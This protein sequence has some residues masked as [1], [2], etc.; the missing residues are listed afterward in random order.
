MTTTS[1]SPLPAGA[2]ETRVVRTGEP[3]ESLIRRI[4]GFVGW[5]LSGFGFFSVRRQH[6]KSE[7]IVL[8]AV[9]QSFYVWAL[10]LTGFI[11]A[12]WVRH[13]PGSAGAWGWIY[14]WVLLYTLITLIYD[15]SS[16]KFLLWVGIFTFIWLIGR[17]FEDMKYVPLVQDFH[18]FIVALR[19]HLDAGF[20]LV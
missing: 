13:W 1:Q 19:P 14:I 7:E 6:S 4:I 12:L 9:H 18:I 2:G 16:M 15:M 3:P 17:Y 5:V 20:A 8:Y 10:V 11:G